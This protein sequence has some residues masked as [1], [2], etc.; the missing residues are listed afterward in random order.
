[1]QADPNPGHLALGKLFRAGLLKAVITQ[2]IDDLERRAGASEV[3]QL[4]GS[5]YRWRCLQCKEYSTVS[6]ES[7]VAVA[8]DQPDMGRKELIEARTPGRQV[9]ELRGL[10]P[11][12]T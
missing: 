5:I 1:M 8:A 7:M 2:N 12:R 11:A 3:V 10:A 4:H 6:R 9:P